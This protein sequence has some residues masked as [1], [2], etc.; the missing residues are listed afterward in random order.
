MPETSP[1]TTPSE[2][3]I[4]LASGPTTR[5]TRTEQIT[6]ILARA[7]EKDEPVRVRIPFGLY[8]YSQNRNYLFLRDTA[9]NLTLPTDQTTPETVEALIDAVGTC[10]AA[11]AGKGSARV[12]AKLAELQD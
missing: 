5:V 3:P 12:L 7:R 1:D 9:W 10:I 2:P 4:S 11:I 8:E 6:E